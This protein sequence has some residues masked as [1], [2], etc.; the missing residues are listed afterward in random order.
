MELSGNRQNGEGEKN[1]YL[2]LDIIIIIIL[3]YL[4]RQWQDTPFRI[5]V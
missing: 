5:Y 3:K 4:N 2:Y 1:T